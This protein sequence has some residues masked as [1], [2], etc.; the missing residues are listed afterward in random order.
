MTRERLC[1]RR[2]N[3]AGASVLEV[4]FSGQM[5]HFP[6]QVTGDPGRGTLLSD[7]FVSLD[8]GVWIGMGDPVP[9]PGTEQ[10]EPVLVMRGDG[11]H[12]DG[13]LLRDPLPLDQGLTVEMDFRMPLNG[14]R[15][16][17][18]QVCLMDVPLAN[19]AVQQVDYESL[20]IMGRACLMHPDSRDG[21]EAIT[22]WAGF[23]TQR[24]RL[25]QHLP[26][27]DWIHVAL[28]VRGDGEVTLVVNREPVARAVVRLSSEP[29]SQWRIVLL[30]APYGSE[31]LVRQL[32]V[33]RGGAVLRGCGD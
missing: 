6:V 7:D 26:S 29:D 3:T 12:E 2:T 20:P 11:L 18:F 32:R 9:V 4:R 24:L 17:R 33:W 15:A 5:R 23:A 14:H 16:Q 13:L 19:Q 30:G 27:D 8:D 31:L 25:P 22:L 10:G 28:Q 1:S 21:G